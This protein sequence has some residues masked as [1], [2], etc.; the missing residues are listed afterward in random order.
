M[1]AITAGGTR[2]TRSRGRLRAGVAMALGFLLAA[3]GVAAPASGSTTAAGV[4]VQTHRGGAGEWPANSLLALQNSIAAGHAEIEADV[5]FTSDAVAVLNHEDTLTA[6]CTSA[7]RSIH[8]MTLAQVRQ[9]SCQGQP[10]PTLDEGIAVIKDSGTS[11]LLEVK[12]YRGQSEAGKRSA[13][14]RAA[15]RLV[16]QGMVGQA[17]MS[18]A[19]WRVMLPA[20]RAVSTEIPVTVIESSPSLIG[21]RD[22]RAAGAT[23]Y[24]L[25]VKRANPFLLEFARSLG[26]KVLLWETETPE[27]VA[28]AVD[29]GAQ[30]IS[31]NLPTATTALLNSPDLLRGRRLVTTQIP[32]YTISRAFYE[33]RRRRYPVVMGTAVPSTRISMLAWVTLKVYVSYGDGKGSIDIAPHKSRLTD[34]VSSPMPKG[35]RTFYLNVSPGDLG[36]LRVFTTAE[37]AKLVIKVVGYTHL[38]Y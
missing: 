15:R 37:T 29:M 3:V 32:A 8:L 17:S 19:Q 20:I 7:G 36:K 13:A 28:Y 31:S 14:S 10:I 38:A 11:L 35:S 4:G 30:L 34:A 21:V 18:A 16:D 5:L 25:N 26:L 2:G 6:R 24:S 1:D 9:V 12:T 23:T 33:A 22:A 27:Q